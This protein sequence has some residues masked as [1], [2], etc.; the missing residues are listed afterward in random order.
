MTG[1]STLESQAHEDQYARPYS[2]LDQTVGENCKFEKLERIYTSIPVPVVAIVIFF[3]LALFSTSP[4]I[5]MYAFLLQQ[6]PPN[7]K[8]KIGGEKKK[9]AHTHPCHCMCPSAC[10]NSQLITPIDNN[11]AKNPQICGWSPTTLPAGERKTTSSFPLTWT[12]FTNKP[13]EE[14]SCSSRD[15][16]LGKSARLYSHPYLHIYQSIHICGFSPL[17]L[18]LSLS[19]NSDSPCLLLPIVLALGPL[20]Q[21]LE[22]DFHKT[23]HAAHD[24]TAEDG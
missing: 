7:Q 18:S 4:L 17:S 1:Y 20:R 11:P 10:S 3:S 9:H 23:Q 8:N 19:L 2:I 14:E 21:T 12:R 6:P 13:L 22:R 16:L 5:R 24:R 15:S